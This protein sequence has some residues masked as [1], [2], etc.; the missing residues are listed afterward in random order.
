[1][2][3]KEL[4]TNWT[5][6]VAFLKE[7]HVSTS[8]STSLR[9]RSLHDVRVHTT[10]TVQKCLLQMGQYTKNAEFYGDLTEAGFTMDFVNSQGKCHA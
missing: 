2:D 3:N 6:S 7:S 8:L 5:P 1:M 10:N 9:M 4:A